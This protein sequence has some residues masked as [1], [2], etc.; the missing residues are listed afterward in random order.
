MTI[1]VPL[2]FSYDGIAHS[3]QGPG[4][5]TSHFGALHWGWDF[6]PDDQTLLAYG[7]GVVVGGYDGFP[8]GLLPNGTE[9]SGLGNYLTVQ[10]APGTDHSF[11]VTYAHLQL[12]SIPDHLLAEPN[13]EFGIGDVLGISGDTGDYTD[14]S[15]V[16]QTYPNHVHLHFGDQ[17]TWY[18][19]AGA[20]GGSVADGS[21]VATYPGGFVTLEQSDSGP[22]VFN[23]YNDNDVFFSNSEGVV[24]WGGGGGDHVYLD[25]G[26]DVVDG[27]QG[28]DTVTYSGPISEY[29]ITRVGN[30]VLVADT[31][32]SD[33]LRNVESIEFSDVTV[34]FSDL[35]DELRIVF[36]DGS[37]SELL[38]GTDNLFVIGG[39]AHSTAPIRLTDFEISESD[40]G[41]RSVW[42]IIRDFFVS[43]A[44]ADGSLTI[45]AN[46]RS[47]T[48]SGVSEVNVANH[49]SAT[50]DS[51][52]N[53]TI[54]DDHADDPSGSTA[55]SLGAVNEFTSVS[56]VREHGND[57]DV[58]EVTLT[59]DQKI[60]I[61]LWAD[62]TENS[63]LDP[64]VS[65]E[66]PDGTT[67][68]NDD[69][70]A[71]SL[72]SF[73][74]FTAPESGTYSITA[75][76]FGSTTGAY[77]LS[78]TS[79]ETED[80]AGDLEEE[81]N[82]D[83]DNG[84]T[85][86]WDWEGDD[87][88]DNPS[89]LTLEQGGAPDVEDDNTYRGHD[90]DDKIEAD[91]GDDVVWGDSGEDRLYGE[92]GDDILRGGQHDD[93]LYGGDDDDLLY[94][95]HGDDYLNGGSG[96]DTLYGGDDND[97]LRGGDGDDYI[98]GED[99]DDEIR[100]DGGN[101]QIYGDRGDDEIDGD[102]GNDLLFGGR[103]DDDIE[104]DD[105]HDRLAGEDGN[106]TLEGGDGDDQLFGG[107]DDDHLQGGAGND[108][109]HGE[110]G[111]DTADFSDGNNGVVANLFDEIATS[112]DLGYD[113]LYDIENLIGSDGDD[114]FDGNHEA[115]SLSG[116]DG[117]DAIRGH[118]GN[119]TIFGGDDDDILWGDAGDDTLHGEDNDDEL[120]GGLG[121]D[122]LNGG[123]GD[124]HLRGE[125]DNDTIDGGTG[126]DTVFFWG[127]F[128]DFE[129]VEV[130]PGVNRVTDLRPDGLEGVDT[131]TNVEF[132][133]FFDRTVSVADLFAP[134]PTTTNDLAETTADRVVSVDAAANDQSNASSSWISSAS[135][136]NGAGLVSVI[137]GQV[138][139]DPNGQFQHLSVDQMETVTISY[140]LETSGGQSANGSIEINVIG[141]TEITNLLDVSGASGPVFVDLADDIVTGISLPVGAIEAAT[142]ILGSNWNDELIGDG[143]A[144][145]IRGQLGRDT[146]VGGSGNDNLHGGGENDLLLGGEGRDILMG[147]AHNDRLRGEEGIDRLRGG[148]GDDRLIGGMA[149]DLLYG[150]GGSDYFQYLSVEESQN[151]ANA[152]RIYD[153]VQGEDVIDFMRVNRSTFEFIGTSSFSG[154]G[155]EIRVVETAN[156]NSSIFVDVDGDS[157]S[158]MRVV[159][160]GVTGL[161]ATDFI[162]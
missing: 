76:G 20:S 147:G 91:D 139:F 70:S 23:G 109:L 52:V 143:S 54:P 63:E 15:G 29:D 39:N 41:S 64:F 1:Y 48:Y 129:I 141:V 107:D 162:L 10:Y 49:G 131:L 92:D 59:A 14:S 56:G 74:T 157:N 67:L 17:L 110:D 125:Q 57:D 77:R 160:I 30:T 142:R 93:K 104:G 124:D 89:K 149:A 18:S 5:S 46:D 66:F 134:A 103:G 16:E 117:D 133:E 112:S 148:D 83:T 97:N 9:D 27:G 108:L 42:E 58:Y 118:N 161:E 130:S 111:N 99:D 3:A 132:I 33:H 105:G 61:L 28:T 153:F 119:D 12:G 101:D 127:E 106:D 44:H 22:V 11:Y 31:E 128:E 150:G 75:S 155:M 32:G 13:A 86:S 36:D 151:G 62:S 126:T 78:L 45:E 79:I 53:G 35:P 7:R 95:E 137:G 82:P 80:T 94:G 145:W 140:T 158:D 37:D 135:I 152:D 8:S 96:R 156:G 60:A 26:S 19:F 47:V 123:S 144:N 38:F 71:S 34:D 51:I 122:S 116:L 21:A 72:T 159:V 25:T 2:P 43:T 115:N 4:G 55:I 88:D 136:S 69:L 120:R 65:V 113:I 24:V 98:K 146:I 73:L 121:N 154:S 114:V 90:G 81:K 87:D 138:I 50:V 100:G 102:D 40:V 84:N 6:S 68:S 85:S